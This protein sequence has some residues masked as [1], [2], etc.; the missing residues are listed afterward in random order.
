M[1]LGMPVHLAKAQLSTLVVDV[2]RETLE[3][4]GFPAAGELGADAV[5]LGRDA[6]VDSL[7][8]VSAVMEI[9]QRLADDHG[10]LVSLTGEKALAAQ[11]SPY[12][13]VA[14]LVDFAVS[15][16]ILLGV[17]VS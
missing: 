13:S 14:T 6:V 11:Q 3:S 4:R 5:L 10:V 17:A 1:I 16:L 12:R 7:G 8:L 15:E 9:E 2:L